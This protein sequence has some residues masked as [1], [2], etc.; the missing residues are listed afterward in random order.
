MRA[1]A[2]E[3]K[4]ATVTVTLSAAAPTGGVSSSVDVGSMLEAVGEFT[5]GDYAGNCPTIDATPDPDSAGVTIAAG[6]TTGTL[7]DYD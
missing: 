2:S 1:E 6:K 5:A 3:G 7:D 4:T